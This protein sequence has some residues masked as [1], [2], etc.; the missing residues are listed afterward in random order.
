MRWLR[1]VSIAALFTFATATRAEDQPARQQDPRQ[2]QSQPAKPKP[3]AKKK[4]KPYQPKEPTP[5]RDASNQTQTIVRSYELLKQRNI[6]MQKR[7]FSC[8]AA[9]VATI[10][11]Y[12]WD[13]KVDE[14]LFLRALDR[15]LT[16][17]EIEDRIKN[18]LAM[19]DLRRAAVIAG[20]QSAVGRLT[21][22]KLGESKVPVVVG[23]KPDGHKHFVVYRGT[24]FM[25]VYV[26]DPIRGNL[27]M[28]VREFVSQWQEHAVL[29]LHKPGHKVKEFSALSLTD[30]DLMR[31]E[32]TDQYI[33]SQAIRQPDNERMFRP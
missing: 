23:I 5:I 20:Y 13:D 18:G 24:D 30:A 25:W 26:A 2:Q 15:V 19:S 8:G 21:F 14:D 29:V 11:R 33:R 10:A 32:T 17:A 1:V 7:D 4:E 28:P 6:V 31:G 3:K 16:K 27:R 12:Y 9:A 22:E